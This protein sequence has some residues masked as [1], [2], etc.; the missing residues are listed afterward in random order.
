M[1]YG[2]RPLLVAHALSE[3]EWLVLSLLGVSDHRSIAELDGLLWYTGTRVSYECAA[4]LASAGF[5]TLLSGHDPETRV[6][7]T[8]RGREVVIE[9]VAAAKAQETSA[10]RNLGPGET[11]QLKSLLRHVI[12]DSDPGTPPLRSPPFSPQE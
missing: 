5:V 2:L 6:S 10:E 7:L 3:D 8:P 11:L 9:L 1:M 4:R 12:R